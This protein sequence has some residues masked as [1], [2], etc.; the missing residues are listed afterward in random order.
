MINADESNQG[1]YSKI[2]LQ[3]MFLFSELVNFCDI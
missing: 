3:K 2:S 1:S